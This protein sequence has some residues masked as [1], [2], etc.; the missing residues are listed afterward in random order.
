MGRNQP[1]NINPTYIPNKIL[2]TQ[3]SIDTSTG[4]G[5]GNI[6]NPSCA[7][8]G[9]RLVSSMASNIKPSHPPIQSGSGLGKSYKL[10]KSAERGELNTV[11]LVT[12]AN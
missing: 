9:T 3:A 1:D 11:N 10:M 4:S 12:K 6:V 8:H 7:V 5:G 2:G